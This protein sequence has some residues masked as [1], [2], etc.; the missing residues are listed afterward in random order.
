MCL[1]FN[2]LFNMNVLSNQSNQSEL[3][4]VV[5]SEPIQSEIKLYYRKISFSMDDIMYM[6]SD[7][8][9]TKFYLKN[10]LEYISGFTLKY[11]L[12]RMNN[13]GNFFRISRSICINLN[14]VAIKGDNNVFLK[15]G[16]Q[17]LVSRRRQKELSK[18]FS[19]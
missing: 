14:Y 18:R 12:D 8:N 5:S 6:Q 16:L 15:N 3:H 1:Y 2:Y 9:Y 11:H 13:S 19:K 4:G 17:F 7:M 10:G